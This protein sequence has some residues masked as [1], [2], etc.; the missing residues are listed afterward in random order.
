[1]S[2]IVGDNLQALPLLGSL[3]ATPPRLTPY[4]IS[5]LLCTLLVLG[6]SWRRFLENNL[7]ATRLSFT[8]ALSICV[9]YQIPLTLF[10]NEVDDA[11][12]NPWAFSLA[13]N[14]TALSLV[15]YGF[16]TKFYD[17]PHVVPSIPRVLLRYHLINIILALFLILFYIFWVPWPCTG[18]YALIYDP[19]QTLLA[20]ELAVKLNSH[21]IAAYALGAYTSAIA[22]ALAFTSLWLMKKS[23]GRRRTARLLVGIVTSVFAMTGAL[24]SGTKGL[25]IPFFIM[26]IVGAYYLSKTGGMRIIAT[27]LSAVFVWALLAGY[28]TVRERSSLVWGRYDFP[29]CAYEMNACK[30]SL[31]LLNSLD[32]RD[33]SLGMTRT[34]VRSIREQLVC[35]CNK[36]DSAVCVSDSLKKGFDSAREMTEETIKKPDQ[37]LIETT[38]EMM[39]ERESISIR[40]TIDRV[41]VMAESIFHRALITPFQVSVWHFMYAETEKVDGIKT[42]PFA[43]RIT[44]SWLNMPELV[45]QKYGVIYSGGDRTATSTSPTSF[46]ISYPAYLGAGGF[47]FALASIILLDMALAR[48]AITLDASLAPLLV[49]LTAILAYNFM[50]SDFFTVITSHGGAAMVVLMGLYAYI[51]KKKNGGCLTSI[52]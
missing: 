5:N 48:I 49:G 51:T 24:L 25:L 33:L 38:K 1:M 36:E 42:L 26:L 15:I 22:P 3:V 20:R 30:S 35:L 50:S 8:L 12:D 17:L 34:T 4:F 13:V 14:G 45:Y 40:M 2:M 21:A 31:E 39:K 16:M 32:H 37:S 6:Y 43:R 46:I 28:E 27:G 7:V 41:L 47:L 10:S 19:G 23:E 9:V 52:V 11:L 29:A 44:G 18:L